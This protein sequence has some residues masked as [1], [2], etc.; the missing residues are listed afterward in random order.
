MLFCFVA[1]CYTT[2]QLYSSLTL[3]SIIPDG[4]RTDLVIHET[5]EFTFNRKVY[6]FEAS[7]LSA[8]AQSHC[9]HTKQGINRVCDSTGT[10]CAHHDV[11]PNTLCC[12]GASVGATQHS[13]R[14]C[15]DGCCDDHETCTS[16]CLRPDNFAQH[17]TTYITAGLGIPTAILSDLSADDFEWCAYVCRTSSRA[18]LPAGNSYSSRAHHHCYHL[19]AHSPVEQASVNSDRAPACVQPQQVAASVASHSNAHSINNNLDQSGSADSRLHLLL[20][21]NDE[22]FPV[23]QPPRARS[24]NILYDF[25]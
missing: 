8:A 21:R 18:L 6:D 4:G 7:D 14:G 3:P 24:N 17:A 25:A 5:T 10:I 15:R 19:G 20:C 13:C 2:L 22:H 23:T 11:D 9:K 1:C 12:R 16:C